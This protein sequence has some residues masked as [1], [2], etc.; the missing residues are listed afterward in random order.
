MILFSFAESLK[1]KLTSHWWEVV[2]F[3]VALIAHIGAF[4]MLWYI[5]N[6]SS[7]FPIDGN[8]AQ[9]YA[10]L[11]YNIREYGVFSRASSLPLIPDSL[12]TP[13]YPLLVVF[14]SLVGGVYGVVFLQYIAAAFSGVLLYWIAATIMP[15]SYA[16]LVAF[17]FVL[18]PVGLYL[19]SVWLSET[20]FTFLLLAAAYLCL[21]SISPIFAGMVLGIATLVRPIGMLAVPVL[22]VVLWFSTDRRRI[23]S[24]FLFVLVFLLILTPW[25]IR[26]KII[27]D[28][29][30][31]SR[32]STHNLY[33]YHASLFYASQHG[34][35]HAEALNIF[36][37]R[38]Q[39]IRPE[40]TPGEFTFAD[41][42]ALR[43][44]AWGVIKSDPFG[45]S[46]FY[47]KSIIPFFITDG[48]SDVARRAGLST[49]TSEDVAVSRAGSPIDVLLR[50]GGIFWA[51]FIFW[52]GIVLSSLY[53]IW[54]ARRLMPHERLSV[55]MCVVLIALF[56]FASGSVAN[57]RLRYPVSP[58]FFV[59]SGFGITVFFDRVRR[60]RLP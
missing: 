2:I 43:E 17:L 41:V 28:T 56:A 46:F 15:L 58:F 36:H 26:N 25:L 34:I 12:R 42:P 19:S 39:R 1:H 9:G 50:R 52:M 5:S 51:G 53:G 16:R 33:S 57:G 11:A 60:R 35:S 23:H 3:L 14:G 47:I 59:L 38:L 4:C 40:A 6:D 20:F 44:V 30:S 49:P 37:A 13:G 18:E 54:G 7:K 10:T 32:V 21:H 24:M 31:L 48:W 55:F 27:F 22:C 45:F 8:D 29:W